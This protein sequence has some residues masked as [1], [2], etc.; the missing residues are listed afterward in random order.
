MTTF[1][2]KVKCYA[3]R[4]TILQQVFRV[5]CNC[6]QLSDTPKL[7]PTLLCFQQFNHGGKCLKFASVKMHVITL[8]VNGIK[9]GSG[10]L[11]L[12]CRLVCTDVCLVVTYLALCFLAFFCARTTTAI[13]GFASRHNRL[14]E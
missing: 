6:W 5:A 7:V 2:Q 4:I 3:P 9:P 8:V 1:S 11:T 12:N 14:G 10:Q 13:I